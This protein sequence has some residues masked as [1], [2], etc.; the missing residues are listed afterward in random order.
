M[1]MILSTQKI[2]SVRPIRQC[3]VSLI[4]VLVAILVIS[5]G[6]LTMV[7]MQ[8]NATKFTKTSEIRTMGSMLAADL[9]D[10]M[11]ANR[12]GFKANAYAYSEQYPSSGDP[13]L[14]RAK[15]GC[16]TMSANCNASDMAAKDQADWFA[17]V[18]RSLPGGTAW[19]GRVDA[20]LGVDI[21]LIWKEPA[22]R[23]NAERITQECPSNLMSTVAANSTATGNLPRCM[24][25]RVNL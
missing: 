21:W 23:D 25:F 12:A 16:D 20:S 2:C 10:R 9:A 6:I 1:M 18:S 4:E 15:T 5:L 3:G 22:G 14:P 7:A 19:I 13:T 8:V 17:S 11:R 24:Y